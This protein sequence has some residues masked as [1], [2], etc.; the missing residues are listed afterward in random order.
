MIA[1]KLKPLCDLLETALK[2]ELE[3]QGHT[4]TGKLRDSIKVTVSSYSEGVAIEGR[5][6]VYGKYVDWGRRSGGKRVPIDALLAWIQV[7]GFAQGKQAVSLAWAI[8]Y[9]IWKNGVPTNRDL[10]KTA[11]VTR[12]LQAQRDNIISGIRE[13]S[14]YFYQAELNNIIREIKDRYY[15]N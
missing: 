3:K 11:F 8:Q 10:S 4:A 12:T 5:A 1:E 2:A 7:K 9:S 13:A 14:N 15:G 6:E